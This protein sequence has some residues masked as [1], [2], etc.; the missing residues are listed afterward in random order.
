MMVFNKNFNFLGSKTIKGWRSYPYLLLAWIENLLWHIVL[1]VSAKKPNESAKYKVTICC[2]FKNEGKFLKE[3]ILY[4]QIIGVDH[5]YLYNNNSDDNYLEVLQ[6]F[7]SQE[8]VTLI[9]WPMPQGQIP[10]YED[11]YQRYRH[12][13]QWNS[14]ID[15][16]EFICPF[17]ETNVY[18]W[19]KQYS[20]YPAVK[21]YWKMFGTSGVVEHEDSKLVTEQ[22]HVCWDKPWIIGKQFYNTAYDI[23]AFKINVHHSMNCNV[24]FCGKTLHMPS[25][26]EF[27]CYD[28]H[29]GVI[30]AG[31]QF[32]LQ[33]NH[34][35]SK[36]YMSY[37]G[38]IQKS[39]S[40]H[41]KNPRGRGH[42]MA[43]ETKCTSSDYHIYRFV[44]Q[45]KVLYFGIN[46]NI[47]NKHD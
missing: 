20:K 13:T 39:D 45:L 42:F 30:F 43:L 23:S 22:Y 38:L 37:V 31:K 33:L 24:R 26:N 32:T 5:I 25:V 16:D 27:K 4:N 6:P 10:A 29:F 7:I 8:Y 12:E 18:Q 17:H 1:L 44:T 21:M 41:K 35:Q 11:W 28:N 36:S 19:L 9:D 47:F 15:I 14:F 3:W 40:A 34:Y 46:P 2:M